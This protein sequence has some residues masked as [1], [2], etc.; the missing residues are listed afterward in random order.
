MKAKSIRQM[1]DDHHMPQ[2]FARPRTLHDNPF[3]E[4]LFGAFKTAPD[5]QVVSWIETKRLTTLISFFHGTIR[6]ICTQALIMSPQRNATGVYGKTL[7]P[8]VKLTSK[9]SVC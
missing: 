9:G 7:S 3:V 2:L 8:N 5:I 6:S 1:F 4:A